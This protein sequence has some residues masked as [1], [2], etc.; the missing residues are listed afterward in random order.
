MSDED[1]EYTTASETPVLSD[2]G[3]SVLSRVFGALS[4]QRRRY[5]LYYLRDNEQ[6]QVDELACQIAAWE[7]NV[8]THEVSD[9]ATDRVHSELVHTHLPKLDDYGLVDYDQRSGDIG[10]TYPPSILDDV[11]Q[12]AATIEDHS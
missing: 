3:E 5:A 10:Y 9:E 6:V 12:L 4:H 1:C 2:G 7:W 11:L 8:P